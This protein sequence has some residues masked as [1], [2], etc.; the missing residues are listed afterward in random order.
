MFVIIGAC[1]VLASVLG[2]FALEGGPF[3]VLMQFAEFLIIGGSALGALLISAPPNLLKKIIGK[4]LASLKGSSV[5]SQTYL[6]L[7][8]LM[9]ESSR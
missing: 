9:Y 6:D 4:V 3:L 5:S 2:G 1:V 8:K 7:M